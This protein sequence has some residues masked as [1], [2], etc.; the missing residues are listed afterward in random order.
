MKAQ[1]IRVSAP[2][3]PCDLRI[4]AARRACIRAG[5]PGTYPT[6]KAK[7]A[8]AALKLC[9]AAAAQGRSIASGPVSVI[10]STSTPRQHRTGPAAGRPMLDCDAPIKA[11]LDACTRA[12]VWTDDAQVAEL[13]VRGHV[14]PP[15]ITITIIQLA[16]R[17]AMV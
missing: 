14:G 11:I 6:P 17:T 1:T 13:V 15:S 5:K 10:I 4:N 2:I 3:D 8:A 7:R 16:P 9:I 12:E